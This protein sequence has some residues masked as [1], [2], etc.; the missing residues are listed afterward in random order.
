MAACRRVCGCRD[1]RHR[2]SKNE[3]TQVKIFEDVAD[4]A[5][6]RKEQYVRRSF[7]VRRKGASLSAASADVSSD[8]LF[9]D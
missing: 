4:T 7:D 3:M 1:L 6:R 2:N 8:E 5:A 9:F